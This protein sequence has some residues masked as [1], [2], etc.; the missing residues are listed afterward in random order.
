[1]TL[2][3]ERVILRQWQDRDLPIF[4]ELNANPQVMQYFPQPLT[5]QQSNDMA[6]MCKTL[7]AKNG[8]G[9][10]AAELKSTSEF[11]GGIGLHKPE[12][13]LPFSPCV[14]IAW[15]LHINYWGKGYATEAATKALQFCFEELNE[16]EVVSFTTIKNAR[17][18]AVMRRLGFS[19]T[20]ENFKHPDIS[21][22]HPLSEHVLYKLTQHEWQ[23]KQRTK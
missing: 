19:N 23:Q 11:I 10:W 16:S 8:W 15:R 18:R 17:S 7:I 20:N 1:M 22:D 5:G 21:T 4:A 13:A 2:E 9:L 3:T 12:S 14:E 6:H